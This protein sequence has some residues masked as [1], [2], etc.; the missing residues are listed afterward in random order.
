MSQGTSSVLSNN[1]PEYL[2]NGQKYSILVTFL[3]TGTS[4]W[5]S[6]DDYKLALYE[7][8]DNMYLSNVWGVRNV[9]LTNDV[10]PDE[11]ATFNFEVTA[12][13]QTG[14]YNCR[15]TMAKGFEPFGDVT[16]ATL[17][18]VGAMESNFDPNFSAEFVTQSIPAMMVAGQKYP[19]N[20]TVRNTGKTSWLPNNESG[21]K[22]VT[23]NDAVDKTVTTDWS[24]SETKLG[25]SVDPG[26]TYTFQFDIAAPTVGS[27]SLQL[28]MMNGNN[29]FGERSRP[30][31]IT[32]VGSGTN[33]AKF[34]N[35]VFGGQIIT[36]EM[37]LGETYEC[38]VTM[39]NT[40]S[41]TW[42]RDKFK[43]VFVDPKINASTINS[44]NVGYIELPKSVPPGE[45]VTITFN[46]KSP[47]E[48]GAF[49]F[50]M[51][52][53]E[54]NDVFGEPTTATKVFVK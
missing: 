26:Q 3:N 4:N 38:S 36:R 47:N 14:M 30:M 12:P 31:R 17:V 42:T 22:L 21:Y 39:V 27:Q 19:V 45:T 23:I 52:M 34:N 13:D 35:S 25:Q 49:P 41:T 37:T 16:P 44:F 11:K 7:Q 1:I 2:R 5:S 46:V 54:G 29:Y 32:V 48:P 43:L 6:D 50:Q 10:G 18:N 40:G 33:E 20:V 51:S 53:M 8:N 15:W 9:S 24:M 28:V